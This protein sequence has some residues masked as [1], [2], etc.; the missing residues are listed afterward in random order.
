MADRDFQPPKGS[1][2]RRLVTLSGRWAIGATGAVGTKTNGEGMTLTRNSAGNYTVTLDDK[3]VSLAGHSIGYLG[4]AA[5]DLTSHLVSHDVA[6]ARTVVFQYNAAAVAT[7]PPN[8]G[9]VHVT[10]FLCDSTA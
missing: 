8:P 9:E 10:L 7:D 3:Y 6:S 1:L 5:T 2:T 4:I